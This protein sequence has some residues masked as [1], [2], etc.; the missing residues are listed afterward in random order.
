[1]VIKNP[2]I[3]L[4]G[5]GGSGKTTL[6]ADLHRILGVPLISECIRTA[7]LELGLDTISEI[8]PQTR[9][10]LQTVALSRQKSMEWLHAASGFVSDRSRYDYEAYF[11]GFFGQN[12]PV[13]QTYL[14]LS[15]IAATKYDLLIYVPPFTGTPEDDGFRLGEEFQILEQNV[16]RYLREFCGDSAL[17]LESRSKTDRCQEALAFIRG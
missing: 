10:V 7:A 4:M 8:D 13:W 12:S 15:R 1:M 6:A 14:R 3:A 2:K 17:I 9:L 16:A 11:A 5:I